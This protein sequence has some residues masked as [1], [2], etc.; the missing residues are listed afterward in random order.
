MSLEVRFIYLGKTI[1]GHRQAEW[2]EGS[3]GLKC[4]C[5]AN[6]GH[7]CEFMMDDGLVAHTL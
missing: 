5:V 4:V 3:A 2:W 6:T 7:T 1:L